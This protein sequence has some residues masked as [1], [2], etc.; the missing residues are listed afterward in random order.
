MKPTL[1]TILASSLFCALF[2]ACTTDVERITAIVRIES[3]P[4]GAPI[5]I[6]GM[7][8]GKAPLSA[9]FEANEANCFVRMTTITAIPQEASFHTQ[10]VSFPAYNPKDP[11]K[12]EIPDKIVFNMLKNPALANASGE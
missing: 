6:N 9:E 2:S 1:K 10:V 7:N 8:V 3:V 12:S 5:V 11:K 4:A